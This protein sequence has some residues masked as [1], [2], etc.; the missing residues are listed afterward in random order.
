METYTK[1][2]EDFPEG[3]TKWL[4]EAAE[5]TCCKITKTEWRNKFD[6]KIC[7]THRP[8]NAEEYELT[9]TISSDSKNSIEFIEYLIENKIKTIDYLRNC[10]SE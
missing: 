2:F 4:E 3:L 6:E 1:K 9:I 10:L 5:E 7:Y 8:E